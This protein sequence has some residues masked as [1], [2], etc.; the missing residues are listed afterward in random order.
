MMVK[1][2]HWQLFLI[3]FLL[4]VFVLFSLPE[5]VVLDDSPQGLLQLA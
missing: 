5:E 3:L 4:P 2:K 1:I